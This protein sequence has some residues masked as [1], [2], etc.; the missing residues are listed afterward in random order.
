M[1]WILCIYVLTYRRLTK[2]PTI[3]FLETKYV[4]HFHQEFY[5]GFFAWSMETIFDTRQ[6]G[7][8]IFGLFEWGLLV[9][10]STI[11]WPAENWSGLNNH[12]SKMTLFT[13]NVYCLV[14]LR[15]F[16]VALCCKMADCDLFWH[17]VHLKA[18]INWSF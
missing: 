16:V 11:F 18:C 15:K 5:I 13:S 3:F 7:T 6:N 10:V 8:V 2:I 4:F 14:L 12:L 9:R 17:V 1:K